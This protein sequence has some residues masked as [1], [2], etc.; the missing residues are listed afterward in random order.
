VTTPLPVGFRL[1]GDANL[2]R[3]SDGTVLW[4]GTPL[5]LLRLT[6]AGAALATRLLAGEPVADARSGALARRLLD[7]GLAHPCPPNDAAVPALAVVVPAQ[8]RLI[9]LDRC[10]AALDGL[11]VTV[12]DDA[13]SD[14]AGVAEVVARHRARLVRRDVN[15]GPAAAR[16][17]GVV[18]TEGEVI[19]FVDS[20]C[21]V[22]GD[23]LRALARHLADPA[24]A[25]VSPRIADPLLD[26]GDRPALV[27]HGGVVPYVPATAVV[28]R[29]T[30]LVE[31]GGFDE[32]LRYGEDVDLVW[33][34]ATAG[35]SVR[36][37]PSAVAEH[38]TSRGY[39]ARVARRYDYGTSVGPLSRRHPAALRGPALAGL[40]APL[41]LGTL[42][43]SGIPAPAA[44]RVAASAPIRTAVALARWVMPTSADDVAYTL[45]V[46]RSCLSA[47]TITPLLPAIDARR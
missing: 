34:L 39:R 37:D 46:W 19:A 8:D 47:R 42:V 9:E 18:A 21:V 11:A 5:R 28:V 27:R 44:V 29:R 25:G 33:R 30:A 2:R 20:D 32:S 35:W 15:G 31:V 23:V 45:G 7:A 12:V 41:R 13:S 3:A 10:L 24:V 14:V 16:N 4:G 6:E 26:M 40:W 17:S 43:R 36:Y 1:F 38:A 22:A